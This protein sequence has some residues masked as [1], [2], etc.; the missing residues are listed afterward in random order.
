MKGE[1]ITKAVEAVTDTWRKQR[2]REDKGRPEV[3]YSRRRVMNCYE[4]EYSDRVTIKEAAEEC[5]EEAYMKV[6]AG[7]TLPAHARQI[8]YA[9]RPDILAK[10]H[11]R[12]GEPYEL[13]DVY[14]TQTLLPEYMDEHG[15]VGEWDV[16]FDARGHFIEPHTKR[17][18]PLGTLDV[19]HYLH[20][21]TSSHGNSDISHVKVGNEYPT[22]GPANRF[23]QCSLLRRKDF[24]RC[25]MPSSWRSD[26]TSPSCPPRA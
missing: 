22:C 6:S 14:F 15:H 24:Y 17:T 26:M 9:A 11:D 21:I 23:G 1:M 7:G 10:A 20:K 4:Y 2:K 18:I 5:M 16:V 12:H 3:K 13:R 8:M 25:S 19:R